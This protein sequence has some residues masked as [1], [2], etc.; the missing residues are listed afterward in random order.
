MPKA[1]TRRRIDGKPVRYLRQPRSAGAGTVT[2][3]P[4]QDVTIVRTFSGGGHLGDSETFTVPGGMLAT[5]VYVIGVVT[6]CDWHLGTPD[7][8]AQISPRT[9]AGSNAFGGDGFGVNVT[10]W[11]TTVGASGAG[12]TSFSVTIAGSG[13]IITTECAYFGW[14]LRN[15]RTSLSTIDT[16]GDEA[17]TQL[18]RVGG[19]EGEDEAID[20]SSDPMPAIVTPAEVGAFTAYVVGSR[21]STCDAGITPTLT[22][23][24]GTMARHDY[25]GSAPYEMGTCD[26]VDGS[27][28]IFASSDSGE[29]GAL[30]V[31]GIISV[32]PAE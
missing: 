1:T 4:T 9:P 30:V 10:I 16:I 11:A 29:H 26:L 3:E 32:Y 2:Q 21:V 7:V 18:A 25:I 22:V 23:S 13:D 12:D 20:I 6:A 17:F 15:A 27:A 31:A 24:G 8:F 28:T 14:L 5:D 19:C